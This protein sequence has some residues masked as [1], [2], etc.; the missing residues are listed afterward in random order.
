MNSLLMDER[1]RLI[2]IVRKNI[3]EKGWKVHRSPRPSEVDNTVSYRSDD[4]NVAKEK[5]ASSTNDAMQQAFCEVGGMPLC[6]PEYFT[7]PVG[8]ASP[9]AGAGVKTDLP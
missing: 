6:I 9:H 3:E 5:V 4:T 2:A 1:A 7:V 8:D